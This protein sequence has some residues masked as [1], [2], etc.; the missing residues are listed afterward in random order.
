M[1]AVECVGDG[2]LCVRDGWMSRVRWSE[3]REGKRE[4]SV[5]M[6]MCLCV[7]VSV[8]VCVCECVCMYMCV[9]V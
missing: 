3:G 4:Q 1:G 8:N 7:C 2:G 5:Y 6:R 9:C